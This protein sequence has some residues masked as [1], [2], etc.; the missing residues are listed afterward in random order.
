M[1]VGVSVVFIYSHI[2]HFLFWPSLCDWSVILQLTQTSD[3]QLSQNR[4]H[5][6]SLVVK[7]S[8]FMTYP[9]RILQDVVSMRAQ[10]DQ[11]VAEH[12]Q[13]SQTEII[14]DSSS[15]SEEPTLTPAGHLMKEI[16]LLETSASD[17]WESL[18]LAVSQQERYEA[19]IA[20]LAA[21]IDEAQRKLQES[22]VTASSVG[23]LKQQMSDRNV[24]ICRIGCLLLFVVALFE[25]ESLRM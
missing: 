21:A 20:Y 8:I 5:I 23:A 2:F 19:E 7:L 6:L 22:P 13:E 16:T 4:H 11:L 14:H 25:L 10:A 9:Q 15:S 1:M 3:S 12:P 18:K 17:Q 24:C